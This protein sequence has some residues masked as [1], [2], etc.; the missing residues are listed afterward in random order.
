MPHGRLAFKASYNF[1]HGDRYVNEFGVGKGC[2]LG[3]AGRLGGLGVGKGRALER[4]YFTGAA[5]SLL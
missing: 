3:R 4:R 2:Q 5:T 1:A